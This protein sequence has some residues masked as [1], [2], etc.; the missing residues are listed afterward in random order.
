M[1]CHT[2]VDT[3]GL[4]RGIHPYPFFYTPLASP[5]Q[6]TYDCCNNNQKHYP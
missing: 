4:D 2:C 3:Y 5:S 1:K 6:T